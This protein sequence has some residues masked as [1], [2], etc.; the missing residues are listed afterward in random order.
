MGRCCCRTAVVPTTC[1]RR[2][3]VG[4]SR[5]ACC[6]SQLMRHMVYAFVCLHALYLTDV[7]SPGSVTFLTPV[8][9][10]TLD[11]S[12]AVD[13]VDVDLEVL[14]TRSASFAAALAEAESIAARVERHAAARLAAAA[15]GGAGGSGVGAARAASS[16]SSGAAGGGLGLTFSV[17]SAS[18][19]APAGPLAR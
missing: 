11:A 16:S 6:L 1:A 9:T 14:R 8:V 10:H 2:C 17:D 12:F 7:V 13:S 19:L 15:E 18:S 4:T 5:P 3:Q